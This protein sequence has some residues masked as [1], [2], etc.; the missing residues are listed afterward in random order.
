MREKNWTIIIGLIFI[1]IIILI[2]FFEDSI[3]RADPFSIDEGVEDVFGTGEI[4]KGHPFP[5][6]PLD[7]YGTDS[8][9]RNIHSLLI[10]GMK[11]TIGVA[12]LSALFR[13][14]IA[15]PIAFYSGV[16]GKVS[17]TIL[18][19]FYTFFNII[20]EIIISYIVLNQKG[21]KKLRLSSSILVFS[22]ILA[23]IG[24]GKLGKKLHNE[25]KK[26]VEQNGKYNVEKKKIFKQIF[27]KVF[28][29]FFIETGN[30][31]RSL[32]ILGVLGITIGI[33][34]F[35]IS[36]F[37]MS[38]GE[39]HYYYPEWSGMLNVMKEAIIDRKYW[40]PLFPLIGFTFSIIAFNLVGEGFLYE[41]NIDENLF[42]ERM[43]TLGYHL[44]PKTY[45]KEWDNFNINRRNIIIKTS[46]VVV[47]ILSIVFP[48][49]KYT[50]DYEKVNGNNIVNYIEELSKSKYVG[51]GNREEGIN[52]TAKF[53]EKELEEIGLA[54][55]F[56]EYDEEGFLHFPYT[57]DYSIEIKD[58]I[59]SGK[60]IAAYLR[61]Y[62]PHYPLII[63]VDYSYLGHLETNKYK[64]LDERGTSIAMALELARTIKDKYSRETSTRSI[65]FL[66]VDG[67]K[68]EGIG[69]QLAMGTK[70]INSGSFYMYFNCLGAGEDNELYLNTSTISSRNTAFYKQ[71]K[72]AKEK[73]KQNGFK[74]DYEYFGNELILPTTAFESNISGIIFSGIPRHEYLKN[75]YR[76]R[77]DNINNI[78]IEKLED[79]TQTIMDIIS[80]YAWSSEYGWR[81][82][83]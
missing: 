42:Y 8:L 19:F 11:V 57:Q 80:Q 26:I 16:G 81:Y 82:F 53:I 4:A 25:T 10:F 18:K 72:K 20:P 12:V 37:E 35:D 78:N 45:I 60:N 73:I 67:S 24:W 54:P 29:N 32:C 39:V 31:L 59:I 68:Y 22:I 77:Q 46:I 3:I 70:H 23:I 50:E 28:A 66:F 38:W 14:L 55:I 65:V 47:I 69:L 2:I 74:F 7:K 13:V 41:I 49:P 64:G 58:E 5:P 30:V 56:K 62:H 71:M 76:Q 52:E 79:S 21:F 6:N 43:K 15:T 40:I 83:R 9:G 33:N 63:L 61:G 34:K 36:S 27:P 48:L 17:N 1:A 44:S 75:Y 51:N